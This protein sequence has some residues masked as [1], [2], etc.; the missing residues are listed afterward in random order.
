VVTVIVGTLKDGY[1]RKVALPRLSTVDRVI[2][3]QQRPIL[4]HKYSIGQATRLC[5]P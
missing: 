3:S 2:D 1:I 4:V 5:R